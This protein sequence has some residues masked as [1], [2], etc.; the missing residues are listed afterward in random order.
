MIKTLQK[1]QMWLMYAFLAIALLVIFVDHANA[2][3]TNGGLP[4]EGWLTKLRQSVSGPV[5]FGVAMIGIVVSGAVLI[6]GGELNGFFRTLVF[7]VL[8]MALLVGAN[9][10]LTSFFGGSAEI[11]SLTTHQIFK[12]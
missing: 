7:I 3:G 10:M 6:F 1:N 12:G 4:Y 9:S 8:V 11:A 5:A 2:A